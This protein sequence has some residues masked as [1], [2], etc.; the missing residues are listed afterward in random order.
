MSAKKIQAYLKSKSVL[1]VDNR[2]AT[3]ATLKK[4]FS[5]LGVLKEKI[6]VAETIDGAVKKNNHSPYDIIVSLSKIGET[7]CKALI[8]SH[9]STHPNRKNAS[10]II[11]SSDPEFGKSCLALD[12]EADL[13]LVEPLSLD[14]IS[15]SFLKLF[16]SK[17][18]TNSFK[19]LLFQV[20][21]LIYKEDFE[22]AHELIGN[23]KENNQEMH[24][25]FFL[26]GLI[27]KNL[28]KM[29][30]A[31]VAFNNSLEVKEDYFRSLNAMV[32]IEF[33][34]G[35]F[36]DAYKYQEKLTSSYKLD[37]LELPRLIKLSLANQ[38]FTD[39]MKYSEMFP[40]LNDYAPEIK[41]SLSAALVICGK[42]LLAEGSK[43][44]GND[45]LKSAAKLSG[46]RFNIIESII[47]T[48]IAQDDLDTAQELLLKHATKFGE[49]PE[50]QA[51]EA[52]VAYLKGDTNGCLKLGIPLVEKKHKNHDVFE[53]VIKSSIAINRRPELIEKLKED[54]AA[55]FPKKAS[56]FLSLNG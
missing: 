32:T 50:F 23:L 19:E 29:E 16:L 8:D 46:G 2:A 25:V 14:V 18:Q 51:L 7:D 10:I 33:G 48:H 49:V 30:E 55:L 13:F 11:T 17:V 39:I 15:K 4:V 47:S 36:I 12:S 9:I 31:K 40:D 22:G 52:Q 6:E 53:I 45:C 43:A 54:A 3:K 34:E 44:H 24:E 37:P 27:Y 35:N 28:K 1:I 21:E 38:R 42:K 56:F 26:E 5:S 20:K 41:S